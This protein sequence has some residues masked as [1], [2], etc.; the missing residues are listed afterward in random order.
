MAF[1]VFNYHFPHN[2]YTFLYTILHDCGTWQYTPEYTF[3]GIL[4]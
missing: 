4:P 3:T 1:S 2:V